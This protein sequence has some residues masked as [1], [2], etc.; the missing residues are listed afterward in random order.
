[1]RRHVIAVAAALVAVATAAEA[2]TCSVGDCEIAGGPLTD[3]VGVSIGGTDAPIGPV[4][5]EGS[6]EIGSSISHFDGVVDIA[7]DEILP[8][9]SSVRAGFANLT[10]EFFQDLVSMAVIEITDIDGLYVNQ[11]FEV[12]LSSMS[13]VAFR[14]SG[15]AFQNAGASLPDYNIDLIG[16][17][18]PGSLSLLI[19]GL[20]GLGFAAR[21]GKA[22]LG[23]Y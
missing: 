23:G 12:T 6:F 2:A 22:R 8:G 5:H 13:D 7:F 15:T 17:P 20:A 19:A 14:L 9:E 3:S 10:I 4:L 16:A 1:M 21:R 18:L 11:L